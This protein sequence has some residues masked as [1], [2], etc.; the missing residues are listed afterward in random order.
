MAP[1]DSDLLRALEQLQDAADAVFGRITSRVGM[2][3]ERLQ[4]LSRRIQT[5]KANVDSIS[6]SRQAITVL[7]SA[8]YP[9]VSS[10]AVDFK[11]L[12]GGHDEPLPVFK[13]ELN[14]GN[15]Q[16]DENEG[17]LEL[18]RFFMETSHE[19]LNVTPMHKDDADFN[20]RSIAD[21]LP[22]HTK[23]PEQA[24]SEASG[25]STALYPPPQSLTQRNNPAA[26]GLEEYGFKPTLRQVP[27]FTLPS[28][29]PDLPMVAD[30]S[31]TGSRT[32][33][34]E[35]T[36]IVPSASNKS[37][38]KL[39]APKAEESRNP[40]QITVPPA[41]KMEEA[42]MPQLRPP[43]PPPRL[44][45]Q[46]TK[47][48]RGKSII[49]PPPPPLP[50]PPMISSTM[51]PGAASKD[52]AS[53]SSSTP[54]QAIP[55]IEPNRAALLASIR[56][57]N[58]KL[59][60]TDVSE[61][62]S[63]PTQEAEPP[64]SKQADLLAEM[65]STLKMRRLSMKGATHGM[66]KGSDTGASSSARSPLPASFNRL[67]FGQSLDDFFSFFAD[68]KLESVPPTNFWQ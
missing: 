17:T 12:F 44:I 32:D 19:R 40:S 42:P 43:Q 65:A 68:C 53:A 60:K 18:F 47:D 58:I 52:K 61:K 31:W 6:G 62:T 41:P 13:V 37:S 15:F 50:S 66:S 27:L 38:Q 9:Q 55:P 22:E 30:I 46:N 51:N 5:V 21:V 67:V 57:P 25:K 45:S 20:D 49:P 39:D 4:D 14:M 16:E 7:S 1:V 10:D 64:H 59:R 35:L 34:Q 63:E 26:P 54:P 2:E 48:D 3:R 36:S 11:P 23:L 56:S 28:K 29:I 8:K 24:T 33:V